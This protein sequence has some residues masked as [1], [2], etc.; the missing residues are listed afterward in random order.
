M[1]PPER[2]RRKKELFAGKI[3]SPGWI[4]PG[5]TKIC[6][7]CSLESADPG[8]TITSFGRPTGALQ[9]GLEEQTVKE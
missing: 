7:V 2:E 6:P 3:L 9:L 8:G 5:T 1:Q 4:T